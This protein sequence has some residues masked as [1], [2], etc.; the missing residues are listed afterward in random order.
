V[1]AAFT[2]P[3]PRLVRRP[4]GATLSRSGDVPSAVATHGDASSGT[5][6]VVFFVFR[7]VFARGNGGV[8]PALATGPLGTTAARSGERGAN[9]PEKRCNGKRGS[10]GTGGGRVLHHGAAR[11]HPASPG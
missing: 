5:V 10:S 8:T 1:P 4:L 2:T 6:R 7:F 11:G 3:S 9:T